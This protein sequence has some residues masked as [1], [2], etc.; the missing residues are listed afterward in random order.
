MST[1]GM[2]VTAA[3]TL[4]EELCGKRGLQLFVLHDFDSSG[5][6]IKQTLITATGAINF[7]TRSISSTSA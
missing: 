5:F 1:K 7:G 6:S 4:V 3:R 2:S